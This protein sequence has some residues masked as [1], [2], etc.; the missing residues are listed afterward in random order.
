MER[1]AGDRETE[2]EESAETGRAAFEVD[3][4][5]EWCVDSGERCVGSLISYTLFNILPTLVEITL[6]L[7]YLVLR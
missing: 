7:G 2:I 3:R 4:Q 6:V 5:R 1:L